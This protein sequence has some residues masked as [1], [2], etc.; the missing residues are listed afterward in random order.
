MDD[1]SL[2]HPSANDGA[3][4][5]SGKYGRNEPRIDPERFNGVLGKGTWESRPLERRKAQPPDQ[6][7]GPPPKQFVLPPR[8]H[9]RLLIPARTKENISVLVHAAGAADTACA[10]LRTY[11][12]DVNA[13]IL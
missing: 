5:R 6:C 1:I 13:T 4:D 9:Y 12:I 2:H 8:T 3:D 10:R 11:G 7:K